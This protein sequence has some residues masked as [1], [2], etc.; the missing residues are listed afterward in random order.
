MKIRYIFVTIAAIGAAA[1]VGA[2]ALAGDFGGYGGHGEFGP[3]MMRELDLSETQRDQVRE[4]ME[5]ARPRLVELRERAHDARERLRDTTPDD[6]NY[7]ATVDEL[8]QVI[9]ATMSESIRIASRVRSDV[10]SVLTP[11]QKAKAVE[12]GE[13]RELRR[14]ERRERRLEKRREHRRLHEEMAGE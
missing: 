9:G 12:L 7:S 11:D 4:I 5:S 10:Y 8:S 13:Q 3:R 1:A 14:A 6:P 2:T